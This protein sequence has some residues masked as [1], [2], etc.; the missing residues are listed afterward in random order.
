MRIKLNK[1][2]YC[3]ILIQLLAQLLLYSTVS[4]NEPSISSP[5]TA[6]RKVNK[7]IPSSFNVDPH[8]NSVIKE[9]RPSV[10]IT[11]AQPNAIRYELSRIWINNSEVSDKCL[12][13]PA[14]VSYRPFTDYPSGPI[15]VRAVIIDINGNNIELGWTFTIAKVQHIESVHITSRLDLGAFEDL[16]VELKGIAKADRA[17][18]DIED[19]RFDIP[20]QE[21]TEHPGLYKGSYRIKHG[22]NRLRAR[23]IGYLQKGSQTFETAAPETAAIW[24][25]LFQIVILEPQDHATVP[26]NFKIK[27]RTL[28]NCHISIIPK[29]GFSD[30][31]EPATNNAQE[32]I[33]GTIPCNSDN[34]G[35]FETDYGFLVKLPGMQAVFTIIAVDEHGNRSIPKNFQVKFK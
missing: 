29:I 35:Y 2:V 24:G 12:K 9:T 16:T 10:V 26:L 3:F 6:I 5:S 32:D 21:D 18:F 13:T 23:V 7:L 33:M 22:D 30:N 31:I 17:W 27:G 20:L 15:Q 1:I 8:P 11:F 28:P 4:A 34:E 25:Q 19:Y 14:F